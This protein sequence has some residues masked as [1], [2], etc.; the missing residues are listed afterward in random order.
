FNLNIWA[1][2]NG[3]HDANSRYWY[4]VPFSL[5]VGIWHHIVWAVSADNTGRLYV[6]G[7]EVNVGQ[8]IA[9]LGGQLSDYD[10]TI[11]GNTPRN[12]EFFKGLID[13]VVVHNRALSSN[14]V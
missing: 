13:E 8:E 11:G 7:S 10:T 2:R 5:P 4:D 1:D 12:N 9:D 6:D 14:E 3:C